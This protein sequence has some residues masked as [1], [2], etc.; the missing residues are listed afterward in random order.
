[1]NYLETQFME[2]VLN[3]MAP[4]Q[5]HF[6]ASKTK[7]FKVTLNETNNYNQN[8]SFN[9]FS[10]KKNPPDDYQISKNGNV[11]FLKKT[12]DKFD[13]VFNSDKTKSVKVRKGLVS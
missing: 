3:S 13:R 11:E 6:S 9:T 8:S 5:G 4:F 2:S 1:M 12:D 10:Y 7:E